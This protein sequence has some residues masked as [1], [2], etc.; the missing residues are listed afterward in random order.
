MA[1]LSVYGQQS[2]LNHITG[3]VAF[4]KP[5]AYIALCTT[6]PTDLAVGTEAAYTNYAR[7][8]TAPADWNSATAAS[9]S[10]ASNANIVSFPTC[11]A[12]GATITNFML[13]DALTG[14]NM[15]GWG[16]ASLVVSS[17]ITPQFAAG[18]LVLTAD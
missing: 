17:G 12:T 7:V 10:V 6:A 15:I 2:V 4:A 9:P 14:G 8:A 1:G 5:T 18:A 13:M 16:T 11:G 3:K